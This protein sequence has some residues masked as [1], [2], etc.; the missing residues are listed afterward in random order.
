MI[1]QAAKLRSMV[2]HKTY[3]E[4]KATAIAVASG[5][6]GVGKSNFALNF[7]LALRQKGKKVLLIDLDSGMGNI[8]ILIGST[9]VHSLVDLYENQ[10]TIYDIIEL[11]PKS[12]H[13]I[14][15]G[16]AQDKIFHL[17]QQRLDYFFYQMEIV[18]PVYDFIILDLGA[19]VTKESI[20]YVLAAD[21]C[22]LVT[23]PEPTALTDAYA[24]I[25]HI[26]LQQKQAIHLV[27]NKVNNQKQGRECMDRMIGVV[28]QFLHH[29]VN[30]LAIIPEDPI[31][32]KSVLAQTPF[33]SSSPKALSS[34]AI[35]TAVTTFIGE[36][37][38]NHKKANFLSKLR[39]FMLERD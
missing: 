12:L 34:K 29:H 25:K 19:G 37:D 33:Y 38:Q 15:G 16:N 24:M 11:G 30:P 31:I 3:D 2:K 23:T 17:D 1:D 13:Y 10:L 39:R 4:H 18:F 26:L 7:S 6:G 8:D 28:K 5:K 22:I 36:V 20:Q 9:A 35:D 21:E 32:P 14:A 27:M